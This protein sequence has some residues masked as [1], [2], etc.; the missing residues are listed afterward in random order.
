MLHGPSAD[1][2]AANL[3]PRVAQPEV[4][5]EMETPHLLGKTQPRRQALIAHAYADKEFA[6]KLA[7]ALRRGKVAQGVDEV[8]MCGGVSL[9]SRIATAARPIDVVIPIISS[10]SVASNWVQH[11]VRLV[12][13]RELA[14]RRIVVLPARFDDCAL[15][16]YLTSRPLADFHARGW[17]RAFEDL[18]AAIEGR[19]RLKPVP[20]PLAAPPPTPPPARPAPT[21]KRTASVKHIFLSYD[22][23]HDG[24]YRDVLLS[25]AKSPDFAQFLVN[26]QPVTV[27]VD[28][29]QAEPVKRAITARIG[30]ATAFLCIVG[31]KTSANPWVEWEIRK[32]D[33]LGKRLIAARV[34][35]DCAAHEALYNAGPTWALSFTFEGIKHAIEEA[36]GI[37]V[38]D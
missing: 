1:R 20:P 35:R 13:S 12:M 8:E 26:D 24:G 3:Q 36:Y 23:E 38:T 14:A 9:V 16:P 17:S 31:P 37:C 15:P 25:W 19:A 11:E 2:R 30:A 27:P 4:V 5:M 21:D 18:R 28:S 6:L 10:A 34:N 29:E 32:A 7:W 22:Y 33:E